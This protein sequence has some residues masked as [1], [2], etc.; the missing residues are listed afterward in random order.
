MAVLEPAFPGRSCT[1]SISRGRARLF[2][3]CAD[4]A[5]GEL[6]RVARTIHTWQPQLLAAFDHPGISNGPTEAIII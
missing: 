3:V 6:H 1:A 4:S 5:I 2:T